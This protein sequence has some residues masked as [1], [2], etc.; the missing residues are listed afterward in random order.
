MLLANAG[1]LALDAQQPVDLIIGKVLAG[2]AVELGDQ[3]ANR[4]AFKQRKALRLFA[5]LAVA[6]F[7]QP[8]QMTAVVVGEAPG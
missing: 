7:V 6:D 2:I 8:G 5:I 3:A 1:G 4:I